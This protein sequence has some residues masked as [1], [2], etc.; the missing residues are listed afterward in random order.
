MRTAIVFDLEFTAW[1]DSMANS[2]MRPGEFREVVQIGA[3]KVDADMLA[4]MGSFDMLVRP[5][6]NTVLS[7]FLERLTGITNEDIRRDGR[8][9][10]VVFAE[11]AAFAEG[12]AVWSAFGND[13][14]VLAENCRL[15]GI[16][17]P[18]TPEFR[19]SRP[20]FSANGLDTAGVSSCDIGPLYGVPLEG[21]KH[22]A[23]TDA[24]SVAAGMKALVARLSKRL[25][26]DVLA[27]AKSSP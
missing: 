9:F 10:A 11:F 19:N 7:P 8:D 16:A 6:I 17:Q 24:R 2:W 27:S 12:C 15:Y 22:N 1:E 5:R 20:W 14:L 18:P 25:C 3:V 21:H 23:L 26:S 4:V 13:H